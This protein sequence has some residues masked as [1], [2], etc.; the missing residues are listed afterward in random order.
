MS[1]TEE[2]QDAEYKESD[3]YCD[4]RCIQETGRAEKAD[5]ELAEYK[6]KA[7]EY[8]EDSCSGCTAL[9]A[10]KL[11][12]QCAELKARLQVVAKADDGLLWQEI[13]SLREK[14]K[15]AIEAIKSYEPDFDDREFVHRRPEEGGL[16]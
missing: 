1:K 2:E 11:K 8:A 3:E 9:A 15:I 6:R 16:G 4:M 10:L 13:F 14:L 7:V 12:A 5:A